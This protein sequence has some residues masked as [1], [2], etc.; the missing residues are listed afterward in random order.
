M[1]RAALQLGGV[2]EGIVKHVDD[3][4]IR[5]SIK[6]VRAG[7]AP[8]HEALAPQQPQPLRYS[9]ELLA[10]SFHNLRDA[11]FAGGQQLQQ[12]QPRPIA[13]SAKNPAGALQ[14]FGTGRSPVS[15]GV[16]CRIAI[17][18]RVQQGTSSH[19][20]VSSSDEI[21]ELIAVLSSAGSAY[22]MKK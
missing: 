9:G 10:Q 18:P 14:R 22:F 19:S 4:P 11:A 16:I 20:T 15:R 6:Q 5:E 12:A 1:C 21:L 8:F 3:V 2:G 13:Q 17:G 7:A